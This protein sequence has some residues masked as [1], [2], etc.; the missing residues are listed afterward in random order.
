MSSDRSSC[1]VGAWIDSQLRYSG[2]LLRDCYCNVVSVRVL[3]RC[4]MFIDRSLACSFV[5]FC[6]LFTYAAAG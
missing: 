4:C 3:F 5:R 1:L 2:L 6:V